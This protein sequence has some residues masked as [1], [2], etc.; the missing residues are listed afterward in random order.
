MSSRSNRNRRRPRVDNLEGRIALSAATLPI[1]TLDATTVRVE[2]P[3]QVAEARLEVRPADLSA[4]RASTIIGLSARP[5]AG[6]SLRP[7]LLSALG[8]NG[9]A[10]PTRGGVP[11]PAGRGGE[12]LAFARVSRPGTLTSRIT[13]SH[14]TTGGATASDFLPGDIDGTGTVD[15]ADQQKF[16]LAYLSTT[17]DAFFTPSADANRNGF[18]GQG[19]VKFLLRNTPP[20][21]GP[22]VPLNVDLAL[23]PGEYARG[24]T[25]ETSGGITRL[26][27]VTVVGPDDPAIGRLRRLGTW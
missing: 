10:I 24:A 11:S 7:R 14:G 15:R 16:Q 27:D 25:Q 5:E 9:Q 19:D 4:G 23:A 6:G 8:P 17:K 2:R 3:N 12:T 20:L 13:G 26:T 22:K 1:G 18:I 21:T